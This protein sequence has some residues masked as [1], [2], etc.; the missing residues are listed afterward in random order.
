MRRLFCVLGSI[1]PA[2]KLFFLDLLKKCPKLYVTERRIAGELND[3][4]ANEA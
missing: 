4:L 1:A 2:L 3:K